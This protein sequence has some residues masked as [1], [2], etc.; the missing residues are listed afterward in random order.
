MPTVRPLSLKSP[1]PDPDVPVE[2]GDVDDGAG[3]VEASPLAPVETGTVQATGTDVLR[4]V[5]LA[6]ALGMMLTRRF[7]DDLDG[8]HPVTIAILALVREY[9]DRSEMITTSMVQTF[10]KP[11]REVNAS[12][13]ISSL[14]AGRLLR[15]RVLPEDRRYTPLRITPEGRALLAEAEDAYRRIELPVP[16]GAV[17]QTLGAHP[18]SRRLAGF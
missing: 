17:V 13:M 14:V 10:W 18:N 2:G 7:Q 15:R 8:I 12:R 3:D 1:T 5:C 11:M 4:G 6:E 16:L 9:N